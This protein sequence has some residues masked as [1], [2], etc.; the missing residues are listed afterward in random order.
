MVEPHEGTQITNYS[1]I[2]TKFAQQSISQNKSN[3][4]ITKILVNKI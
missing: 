4:I 2:A 3:T 1:R